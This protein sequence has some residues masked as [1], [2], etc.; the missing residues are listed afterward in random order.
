MDMNSDNEVLSPHEIRHSHH[1]LRHNKKGRKKLGNN[2]MVHTQISRLARTQQQLDESQQSLQTQILDVQRRL[3]RYEEPNWNLIT[4]KVDFLEVESKFL[5]TD[6]INITQKV[7]DLDKVHSSMLELREDV[8]GIENKVD[9]TI[10]DFRKEISKLD[11]NFAKVSI[12][13]V[14]SS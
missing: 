5:R 7:M 1:K 3:D 13:N 14:T 9:K 10:P 4:T 11:V 6:L 12:L 2:K 8:E